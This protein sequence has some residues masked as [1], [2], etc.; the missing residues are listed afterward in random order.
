MKKERDGDLIRSSSSSSFSPSP[1]SSPQTFVRDSV[2]SSLSLPSGDSIPHSTS[3]PFKSFPFLPS[4]SSATTMAS[5][6][7]EGGG[8]V[9]PV[10]RSQNDDVI[11]TAAASQSSSCHLPVPSSFTSSSLNP[12]SPVLC[13]SSSSSLH[14]EEPQSPSL[15]SS[16]SNKE[17]GYRSPQGNF[18]GDVSGSSCSSQLLLLP[19]RQQV[20]SFSPEGSST[21]NETST[22]SIRRRRS[23]S[24]RSSSSSRGDLN[25]P[26]SSLCLPGIPAFF[27]PRPPLYSS[28][29]SSSA[30]SSFPEDHNSLSIST[31]GTVGTNVVKTSVSGHER[32]MQVPLG[33]S[34][35][36]NVDDHSMSLPLLQTGEPSTT[37]NRGSSR[38][39]D[40]SSSS[41]CI[42]SPPPSISLNM[43]SSSSLFF[44]STASS[45]HQCH[46]D[47]RQIS[48]STIE[49]NSPAVYSSSSFA[50]PSHSS[51]PADP[52]S[53]RFGPS[54][55]PPVANPD[56]GKAC[57]V[58]TAVAGEAVGAGGDEDFYWSF[59]KP[60]R[61][62]SKHLNGEKETSFRATTT[63]STTC[64]PGGYTTPFPS[65]TCAAF[66]S[67]N[68]A[69]GSSS[70]S[71][72]MS[73][74]PFSFSSSCCSSLGSAPEKR[75]LI[76]LPLPSTAA[77]TPQSR[78]PSASPSPSSLCS[79]TAPVSGCSSFASLFLERPSSCFRSSTVSIVSGDGRVVPPAVH[80]CPSSS[81]SSS[82]SSCS[83]SPSC[84]QATTAASWSPPLSSAGC[85][86][87]AS[88]SSSRETSQNIFVPGRAKLYSSS[89]LEGV[90]RA[91]LPP[92][93]L[94]F[95]PAEGI[96]SS[97]LLSQP[98][99]F[100]RH[101]KNPHRQ[102]TRRHRKTCP[103]VVH[104]QISSEPSIPVSS[105]SSSALS[106]SSPSHS[107]S[108][109]CPPLPLLNSRIS[110]SA[111]S[112][113]SA[114]L[115]EQQKNW[116]DAP[117][118][119]RSSGP[120]TAPHF[121][122]LSSSP[123]SSTS[124]VPTPV[125]S[126][127]APTPRSSQRMSSSPPCAIPFYSSLQCPGG[128]LGNVVSSTRDDSHPRLTGA[129][130]VST[131]PR[132][133]LLPIAH[134]EE[135]LDQHG[136]TTTTNKE[137]TLLQRKERFSSSPSSRG[138]EE[139]STK[140]SVCSV[141][142]RAP[143]CDQE[144]RSL[145][146]VDNASPSSLPNHS[147]IEAIEG[148]LGDGGETTSLSQMSSSNRL[149]SEIS[150]SHYL[151]RQTHLS[152]PLRRRRRPA[153]TP[154]VGL[155]V[156]P[157]PF[158]RPVRRERMKVL[159]NSEKFPEALHAQRWSERGMCLGEVGLAREEVPDQGEL[160]QK[161]VTADASGVVTGVKV[162]RYTTDSSQRSVLSCS[163][164]RG[165]QAAI[166][167]SGVD[168]ER[169]KEWIVREEGERKEVRQEAEIS[170]MRRNFLPRLFQTECQEDEQEQR[171]CKESE[172]VII[173]SHSNFSPLPPP[174]PPEAQSRSHSLFSHCEKLSL[175]HFSLEK[176]SQ[177]E[178]AKKG[179][180][181]S[182][183][184]FIHPSHWFTDAP[185]LS[186]RYLL[187]TTALSF[188]SQLQEDLLATLWSSL[189]TSS[190]KTISSSEV[191]DAFCKKLD[192]EDTFV[193]D[194]GMKT[195]MIRKIQRHY[196]SFSPGLLVQQVGLSCELLS[197]ELMREETPWVS[198]DGLEQG[199]PVKDV[200][201]NHIQLMESRERLK[202]V[203]ILEEE[204]KRD[205]SCREE[206][207]SLKTTREGDA[208]KEEDR[209]ERPTERKKVS[210]AD[211][212]DDEVARHEKEA[213]DK[214]KLWESLRRRRTR[215]RRF[216]RLARKLYNEAIVTG[217]IFPS[218]LAEVQDDSPYTSFDSSQE[219]LR[220]EIHSKRQSST[221]REDTSSYPYEDSL[222]REEHVDEEEVEEPSDVFDAEAS[223][224]SAWPDPRHREEE[225]V[226]SGLTPSADKR[227]ILQR[228]LAAE[229]LR[230]LVRTQTLESSEDMRQRKEEKKKVES[231]RRN[232]TP[233][234][235]L[236]VCSGSLGDRRKNEVC[237]EVIRWSNAPRLGR[238]DIAR[239]YSIRDLIEGEEEI[240]KKNWRQGG[241]LRG[242]AAT[243]EGEKKERRRS[244][245]NGRGR[246]EMGPI[247]EK[248]EEHLVCKKRFPQGIRIPLPHTE[249]PLFGV[250]TYNFTLTLSKREE[251]GVKTFHRE[252]RGDDIQRGFCSPLSLGD[253]LR[254]HFLPSL[255]SSSP[256]RGGCLLP[257][258]NRD[259]THSSVSLEVHQDLSSS[260]LSLFSTS[261]R[262]RRGS[263]LSLQGEGEET[264]AFLGASPS[265]RTL[266]VEDVV[267][268]SCDEEEEERGGED[269]E[270][271]RR[272][273][274]TGAGGEELL[275]NSA[276]RT[277][278]ETRR[279][280]QAKKA[281]NTRRERWS[282][283]GRIKK[284]E[285]NRLVFEAGGVGQLVAVDVHVNEPQQALRQLFLSRC[286]L[287]RHQAGRL[288]ADQLQERKERERDLQ[289]LEREKR[290]Q[291][292]RSEERGQQNRTPFLPSQRRTALQETRKDT[293]F[294]N[295]FSRISTREGQAWQT[296]KESEL[297]N[298]EV[299][300]RKQNEEEKEK[301][302][303]KKIQAKSFER[304]LLDRSLLRT[305]SSRE[306]R[307]H[308]TEGPSVFSPRRTRVGE[309]K[310]EIE[311][312]RR[313]DEHVSLFAT[314]QGDKKNEGQPDNR[315][316]GGISS[317]KERRKQLEQNS[318]AGQEKGREML[319][320]ADS[321]E[322]RALNRVTTITETNNSSLVTSSRHSI[323]STCS[324]G[325]ASGGE[326]VRS[327]PS[328]TPPYSWGSTVSPAS[329]VDAD[330]RSS[331]LTATKLHGQPLHL[332][333]PTSG[334]SQASSTCLTQKGEVSDTH[335]TQVDAVAG[336]DL[337]LSSSS[338]RTHVSRPSLSD[339]ANEAACEASLTLLRHVTSTAASS[340][341]GVVLPLSS[342]SVKTSKEQDS[343]RAVSWMESSQRE[344]TLTQDDGPA[345]VSSSK[346]KSLLLSGIEKAESPAGDDDKVDKLRRHSFQREMEKFSEELHG[347]W[348]LPYELHFCCRDSLS[349]VDLGLAGSLP[350]RL[351]SLF[352]LHQEGKKNSEV[353]RKVK[354]AAWTM[355]C[356]L[357]KEEGDGKNHCDK[358]ASSLVKSREPEE[359]SEDQEG[360]DQDDDD[361]ERKSLKEGT[362]C[363][364]IAP[365]VPY[366][367]SL[368]DAFSLFYW[369]RD[370]GS[371]PPELAL[372]CAFELCELLR[373]LHWADLIHG[374]LQETNF[375][376]HPSR[377][378][379]SLL[380][381]PRSSS[382]FFKT[383][384]QEGS[385]GYTP[386]ARRAAREE[387][388]EDEE[389][390][391]EN[392]GRFLSKEE[393][394]TCLPP[395]LTP[396]VSTSVASSVLLSSFKPCPSSS[397]L[398]GSSPLSHHSHSSS[399]R[400]TAHIE[401]T[402]DP[403]L[404]SVQDRRRYFDHQANISHSPHSSF[405]SSKS[406]SL[407]TCSSSFH[408]PLLPEG[409]PIPDCLISGRN[410][411]NCA[412]DLRMSL[413][414]SDVRLAGSRREDHEP[415][416]HMES[417][418]QSESSQ[419]TFPR[420][421]AGDSRHSYE[422]E[423][424]LNLRSTSFI[425]QLHGVDLRG[426]AT[427]LLLTFFPSQEKKREGWG[428][429]E[430][431]PCVGN[432]SNFQDEESR[433]KGREAWREG[434][435]FFSLS[436]AQPPCSPSPFWNECSK[437][438][439]I[440]LFLRKEDEM[441]N[442]ET[443]R[444]RN[445]VDLFW[446][447]FFSE[448]S[449]FD[450]ACRSSARKRV[451]RNL[452]QERHKG[453]RKEERVATEEEEKHPEQDKT[454]GCLIGRTS[455]RSRGN[456]E[457]QEEISSL[458]ISATRRGTMTGSNSEKSEENRKDVTV[459]TRERK[460][461]KREEEGA[462]E[463]KMNAVSVQSC[464][465]D[466]KERGQRGK[467]N[468]N[469]GPECDTSEKEKRRK[470]EE[471]IIE[472]E[473]REAFFNES[474]EGKHN[475]F[476]DRETYL[477]ELY[478]E[479]KRLSLTLLERQMQR[480]RLIFEKEPYRKA[481][482]SKH[483]SL[484]EKQLV[485]HA[486]Q[487]ILSEDFNE[488]QHHVEM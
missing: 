148:D 133:C 428:S 354:E 411:G 387:D 389:T 278:S 471:D 306:R 250:Y 200:K 478:G 324:T 319:Q 171:R 464:E 181:P 472:E 213:E 85:S 187:A 287:V 307:T 210:V 313:E 66:E 415:L 196:D 188:L 191:G 106:F 162:R 227:R 318:L 486:D 350:E 470:D 165:R 314:P 33:T 370:I 405:T 232:S 15:S 151:L 62:S 138:D 479:S 410:L 293:S 337:S 333:P 154:T 18:D 180:F 316:G 441:Y 59:I 335:R 197:R 392:Q 262:L 42:S 186:V 388:A 208:E 31:R 155:D 361:K 25:S 429:R 141:K 300:K 366:A 459:D 383:S 166:E 29:V 206:G 367:L 348:L 169:R 77:P 177:V 343:T 147:T 251:K 364:L 234:S 327:R 45:N 422:E 35:E 288:L 467:V 484:L 225:F 203:E 442:G 473:E 130:G 294:S 26:S 89:V 17:Q 416:H 252:K 259:S 450:E 356:D 20:Q 360:V 482:L 451:A 140:E 131:Y 362:V 279:T 122:A 114:F 116:R 125:L 117:L 212:R 51:H 359:V 261:G 81:A 11:S 99:L 456:R 475:V 344:E 352:L 136:R 358:K 336:R 224:H 9:K 127:E 12:L 357:T 126:S 190:I 222:H 432:R 303:G 414:Y 110:S 46:L 220:E 321:G 229:V 289:R 396:C 406:S 398:S 185:V 317:L 444:F 395:Y 260:S 452:L 269:E 216:H 275:T 199:R 284:P 143:S 80:P 129:E 47:E 283:I 323:L 174:C 393:K 95:F 175:Q 291:I 86:P 298:K 308:F 55:F 172:T 83:S 113:S 112:P 304:D 401:S 255:S 108:P 328:I 461:E 13:P 245:F 78:L 355:A 118:A 239:G 104:N 375:L 92:E 44:S 285:K 417:E 205:R 466:F 453:R 231:S 236:G 103:P 74:S 50:S 153:Q 214:R 137:E 215:L 237:G 53:V 374:D 309:N 253:F 431:N 183:S 16:G 373:Q 455:E 209:E 267:E 407:H 273:E 384:H 372:F 173:P 424:T 391:E 159:R 8:G 297:Y 98:S 271:P 4:L 465:E 27:T 397:I 436:S 121:A 272:E 454:E 258:D 219:I 194:D 102:Q 347:R 37:S 10:S 345:V 476:V 21:K 438:D 115:A 254:P 270:K 351:L 56:E 201:K 82:F 230:Q 105:S 238:R 474:L 24:S 243:G 94:K 14:L 90:G 381:G 202:N 123:R 198:L 443:T 477:E 402:R 157:S 178:I 437:E 457:Q 218:L 142:E 408:H 158:S 19:P 295:F 61:S 149:H 281:W 376:I 435:S 211:R 221:K 248:G 240:K 292:D 446:F 124:S 420:C 163:E 100:S 403:G 485:L 48:E 305:V 58:H 5:L 57:G 145:E 460:G 412:R 246:E 135:G 249:G 2:A 111:P 193:P 265:S 332:H 34:K 368:G 331:D 72:G 242:A 276:A 101:Q 69:S 274:T 329:I 241:W 38:C 67:L 487:Q 483:L 400:G 369:D 96:S 445:H 409:T 440:S 43:P 235:V 463:R 334:I 160:R 28:H 399:R 302:D 488:H 425:S 195:Y 119:S 32:L 280:S 23:S 449:S 338:S 256:S 97:S 120:S 427:T 322:E 150:P 301:R 326:D 73:V 257:G 421:R 22:Y 139:L 152:R 49:E 107:F 128:D 394:E 134:L 371:P 390:L 7:N 447:R 70:G 363:M 480:I 469:G 290:K 380:S 404:S 418:L 468:V 93:S 184:S 60:T 192:R 6:S 204:G 481:V 223:I 189:K 325:V 179:L 87:Q 448:I 52:R 277:P 54:S 68:S 156:S 217:L 64:S 76:R 423:S 365:A 168:G 340:T 296:R 1:R 41:V 233:S 377:D 247:G 433:K 346:G 146:N 161:D 182:S 286:F 458:N 311:N 207:N 385:S 426:L 39:T 65:I 91:S 3:E 84:R 268:L 75:H 144:E 342:N 419:A 109:N 430:S 434:I 378:F 170:C 263:I 264:T 79:T 132:R 315:D 349:P 312:D 386:A 462:N 244:I 320:L 439:L 40:S 282:F 382:L 36:K 30:L 164:A 339:E 330:S 299:E 88:P 71:I 167:S 353:K 63:S 226:L 176:E 341:P 228:L 413:H 379:L 266:W 310:G